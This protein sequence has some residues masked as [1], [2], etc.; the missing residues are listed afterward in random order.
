MPIKPDFALGDSEDAFAKS[1]GWSAQRVHDYE[2]V[3]IRIQK[4]GGL[5]A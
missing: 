3:V 1:R 4:R 5:N 2:S